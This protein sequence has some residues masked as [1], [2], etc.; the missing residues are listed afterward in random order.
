LGLEA[1]RHRLKYEHLLKVNNEL[2]REIEQLKSKA[3]Q[4]TLKEKYKEKIAKLFTD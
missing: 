1:D 4:V 2:L 3:H